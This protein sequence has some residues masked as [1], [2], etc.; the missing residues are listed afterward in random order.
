M[1][2]YLLFESTRVIFEKTFLT[3]TRHKEVLTVRIELFKNRSKR[4]LAFVPTLGVAK[5]EFAFVPTF[6]DAKREF[7]F[8]PT[9]GDAFGE[10]FFGRGICFCTLAWIFWLK[11]WHPTYFQHNLDLISI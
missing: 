1:A 6:G 9:F 10:P 4:E 7:A 3:N 2:I 5:R 8:A 11:H